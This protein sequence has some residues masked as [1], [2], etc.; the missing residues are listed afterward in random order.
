MKVRWYIILFFAASAMVALS[1]CGRFK[2]GNQIG[3]PT[4]QIAIGDRSL[5]YDQVTHLWTLAFTLNAYNLPGSAGGTI[6]S[7]NL[8]NGQKLTAGLYITDC[9]P[10][11]QENC[12]PFAVN[13]SISFASYPPVGSYV[14]TGYEATGQNG[15]FMTID[16]ATPLVIH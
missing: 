2:L 15:K 9:P 8:K 5:T 4:A 3:I 14:I 13:Y 7:F 16:L 11:A 6:N 1:G 10:K 12:G